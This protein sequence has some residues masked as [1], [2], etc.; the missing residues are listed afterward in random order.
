MSEPPAPANIPAP[1]P[2]PP[3]PAASP[4]WRGDEG[5]AGEQKR[6]RAPRRQRLYILLAVMLALLGVLL[7]LLYWIRA[8]PSPYFV[9]LWITEYQSRQ[10]PFHPLARQD[11]EA[12]RKGGYFTRTN[13]R[14]FTGQERRL[15]VQELAA[16]RNRG[17]REVVVV[18][19]SAQACT[20][21]QG[22]VFLF[23]ADVDPDD[24][25]SRLPLRE[26]LE[27]FRQCPAKNRLLILDI[28]PPLADPRLGVLANDV[29]TRLHEDLK[30]V[31][32]PGR[33]VLCAC[34]PGQVTQV[35]E[36][37]DRSVFSYYLEEGLRGWADGSSPEARRDGYITA[38]ELAEFVKARVDRWAWRNRQTRQTPMLVGTADDFELIALE[39]ADPQEHLAIPEAQV[40]PA[41]LRAGWQVRDQWWGERHY[42]LAPRLFY[43]LEANLLLAEHNWRAG[44]DPT[45]IQDD[46]KDRLDRLQ[47]QLARAKAF[48]QPEPRS[49]AMAAA[50]GEKPDDGVMAAVKELLAKAGETSTLK[51]DEA[52]KARA[53]LIAECI[54]KL[55]DKSQLQP[56]PAAA[57][58][59][60]GT[61]A[62]KP[63][64]ATHFEVAWAA[65]ELA[66]ADPNPSL[67]NIGILARLLRAHQPQPRYVETLFLQRLA[68]LPS[69]DWPADTV[70]LSLE[71]VRQGEQAASQAE[72][73]LWTRDALAA[74]AETRHDAETLLLARGYAPVAL[75][76]QLFKKAGGE[77]GAIRDHGETV[78]QA[79]RCLDE[80]MA[81]LPAY[82]PYLD[83][84]P[85][86]EKP[87]LAA[88]QAA[89][90][91]QQALA[92]PGKRGLAADDLR[93]KREEIRRR[94][95][96]LRHHLDDLA[97]GVGAWS[98]DLAPTGAFAA[99]GI[100]QLIS[101][102]KD[103]EARPAILLQ[104][105]AV[106]SVPFLKAGDRETL[107]KAGQ[108]LSRRLHEQTIRLDQEED[109]RRT[110]TAPMS[111]FEGDRPRF[112]RE[113]Q[114]RA[115]RRA[116]TSIAVLRLGGL[117]AADLEKLDE[118]MEQASRDSSDSQKLYAL[119]GSL[120]QAWAQRLPAQLQQTAD[121]EVRDRL[122]RIYPAFDPAPL[123]D[124]TSASPAVQ[125]R[126]LQGQRLWAWLAESYRYRSHDSEGGTFF[127]E[128]AREVQRHLT[129]TPAETYLQIA[130]GAELAGLA[131]AHPVL[132][133]TLDFK[134]VGSTQS[135]IELSTLT[136][137][138]DWLQVALARGELSL[139]EGRSWRV[140]VRVALKPEAKSRTPPA[141][142]LVRAQVDGRSY[143]QRVPL[144]KLRQA[145]VEDLHILLS[146][147]EKDPLAAPIAHLRLRP[148]KARQPFFIFVRNPTDKPRNVTVRLT[149]NAVVEKKLTVG[150]DKIEK[151]SFEGAAPKADAELPELKGSLQLV[152]LDTDKNVELDARQVRVDIAAPRE[153]VQITEMKFEPPGPANG[154][155][156]RLLIKLKA[157][158]PLAAPPCEVELV[159]RRDR[160]PGFE[161][162]K[163][164]NLRGEVPGDGKELTLSAES[165]QLAESLDEEGDVYLTVDGRERAFILR[166]TFAR[167]GDPTTPREVTRS[168]IRLLADR[169]ALAGP[170]YPVTVEV[171][172]P[173]PG[174]S[175]ELSLGRLKG[176]EFQNDITP[177]RSREAQ[178]RRIGFSPH[179]ENGTLVFEAALKDW[180]EVLNAS[181][182]LGE[183]MLR[184]RML[185]SEDFEIRSASQTIILDDTAPERVRFVDFRPQ[186]K[187]DAPLTVKAS[188]T[189]RES[190]IKQVFF[191]VGKPVDGKVPP[192]T[193]TSPGEPV[194]DSRTT[195]S[196]RLTLPEKKGPV[197]I[198]VQ[199]INNVGLSTFDTISPE[200]TDADADKGAKLGRI[201]G[202]VMEGSRAQPG[203]EVILR[204]EKGMEKRTVKTAEDGAFS[205]PD[206]PPGKYK[207]SC[208]KV[209]SQ[210]KGEKDVTVEAGKPTVVTIELF[211]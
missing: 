115:V 155:K 47:Q 181:K 173:P 169:Y 80:A 78:H 56:K 10:I 39:H 161:A 101:Q 40:Y 7:G 63:G 53:K 107:W 162:V 139:A 91:L 19:L 90:D 26:V 2:N 54:D 22:E 28:M 41:W 42:R 153:Y 167:R 137:D 34:S 49:L 62:P 122:S 24:P 150:P 109:S 76:D 96:L 87:W 50:Q 65:F 118:A 17:E 113:E 160:I 1:E 84:S 4:R 51:P 103:R 151:V 148:I 183:R 120:H 77:F 195:W 164:G 147:N 149:G 177:K 69:R 197:E 189:D 105:Q 171:D 175:L 71:V 83:H 85:D 165:I 123:L 38:K 68:E 60:E 202:R 185:D 110:S 104:M 88:V 127:A 135:K 13:E 18:Y 89:Q 142:F 93:Q 33:L 168:A 106:L 111:D 190:G 144:P 52:E 133:G 35:S 31:P 159:L 79:G 66:A 98:P 102:S 58:K 70:R 152:L 108:E 9:A 74:A 46:L 114:V 61:A 145:G 201:Q 16:L 44:L 55:K 134:L 64:P 30:A 57:A 136:A 179:G 178:V 138:E 73:F 99:A 205:I 97:P 176:G 72:G 186:V 11:R 163:E 143:Y 124:E 95:A 48:A 126:L 92:V 211:R 184:A 180:H 209:S 21:G 117:A 140:P 81:F 131:P 86:Q 15:L 146:S 182:I 27:A 172:H 121:V 29:S 3:R 158:V 157:V 170:K 174:A 20:A 36:D 203:L 14:A 193:P 75:A 43:Q 128:A 207:V 6:A 25:R 154:G 129:A 191:F 132:T 194:D 204:D 199:F 156:N 200:L 59:S 94:T 82:L 5:S 8:A 187:R 100:E 23:P 192:N 67:E 112:E 125:L 32:D 130:G 210:T 45:W 198:S 188:G 141:G 166:T 206:V 119:A 116:R 37:M 12:F 196:A 208:M